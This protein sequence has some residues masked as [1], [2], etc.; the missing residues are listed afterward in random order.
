MKKNWT[1]LRRSFDNLIYDG[2]ARSGQLSADTAGLFIEKLFQRAREHS[3]EIIEELGKR[4]IKY[5]IHF[6]L[7]FNVPSIL[8][9]GLL[10]RSF[11]EKKPLQNIIRSV[12]PFDNR[13][14]DI[15]ANSISVSF[16]NDK[17]FHAKRNQI[18]KKWAIILIDPQILSQCPCHFFH[19][20]AAS[21][22]PGRKTI[23]GF[24]RMF[25][26]QHVDELQMRLRTYLKLPEHYT[27]NPQAEILVDSVI[28]AKFIKAACVENLETKKNIEA[29]GGEKFKEKILVSNKYFRRRDDS[30][31]WKTVALK[32]GYI[33]ILIN[34]SLK[35]NTVKLKFLFQKYINIP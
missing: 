7:A 6:T 12:F 20:N 24:Q 28:P 18:N 5:L 32:E 25:Y 29:F 4:K 31:F 19:H 21:G 33:Y 30:D 34:A 15:D 14:D 13:F 10:P 27:T 9:H 26:D 1:N 23:N 22:I 17:A 3:T 8:K 11:L 16:P 35:K 2:T